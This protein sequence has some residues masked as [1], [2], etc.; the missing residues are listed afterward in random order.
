[1]WNKVSLSE[2]THWTFWPKRHHRTL[3]GRG[4]LA[5][6]GKMV[7]V[8]GE[9][10]NQ[11]QWVEDLRLG[12]RFTFQQDEDTEH[13][14]RAAMKG[15]QTKHSH[16]LECPRLGTFI[17]AVHLVWLSLSLH[18]KIGTKSKNWWWD[19]LEKTCSYN[20]IKRWFR[21]ILAWRAWIL[22]PTWTLFFSFFICEA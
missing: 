4:S 14:A 1:M 11:L 15:L 20:C 8:D 17:N 9:E 22:K 5:G 2:E 6:T 16:V 18:R 10:E 3:G 12:Q 21:K 13:K 19:V 7:G